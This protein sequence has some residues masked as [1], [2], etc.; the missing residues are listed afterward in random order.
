MEK[1]KKQL[2]GRKNSIHFAEKDHHTRF[3]V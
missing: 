1:E 2:M 3:F